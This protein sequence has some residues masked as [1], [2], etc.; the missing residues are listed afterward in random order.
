MQESTRQGDSDQVSMIKALDQALLKH[1]EHISGTKTG[2]QGLPLTLV[3]VACIVMLAEREEEMSEPDGDAQRYD[4]DE[5]EAE[6]ADMGLSEI[7]DLDETLGL[8]MEKGYMEVDS[9][10]LINAGKPIHT[11]A[12]FLDHAFPGMPGLNLVAYFVQTLDE[13]ESGRKSPARALIQLDTILR[14]HSAKP[15]KRTVQKEKPEVQSFSSP[16]SV[17]GHAPLQGL[18]KFVSPAVIKAKRAGINP[19]PSQPISFESHKPQET[20][21]EQEPSTAQDVP[22]EEVPAGMAPGEQEERALEETTPEPSQEQPEHETEPDAEESLPPAEE[23]EIQGRDHLD[24]KESSREEKP[25]VPVDAEPDLPDTGREEEE[26]DET[27]I[28]EL[29]AQRIA[30]FEEKLAM[31][32]PV[33]NQAPVQAKE[34]AKGRVYY[35]CSDDQCIFISWGRP[36]HIE[37]PRCGNPFLIEATSKTGET[38][39]KCPRATCRYK[40]SLETEEKGEPQKV[41]K[42]RRPR[43]RVVRKKVVRRKK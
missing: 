26:T 36:H 11:M 25:E 13:V 34:T 8:M 17:P 14:R 7:K 40:R 38:T 29:V 41:K 33:C 24:D 27:Q 2:V 39:L 37:C 15:F 42:V 21:V 20:T 6:L 22:G 18:P 43:K 1:L 19:D 4:K 23:D 35:T 28:E 31:Q 12:R 32:C 9:K 3:S 16:A 5:L 10:G 30:A